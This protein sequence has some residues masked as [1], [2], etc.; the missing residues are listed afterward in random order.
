MNDSTLTPFNFSAPPTGINLSAQPSKIPGPKQQ[1]KKKKETKNCVE[2]ESDDELMK[3]NI[4]L[5]TEVA[6]LQ[7]SEE[8]WK[9]D[10]DKHS[11]ILRKGNHLLVKQISENSTT[12][13][14]QRVSIA[15]LEAELSDLQRDLKS[16][17]LELERAEEANTT[18]T[19]DLEDAQKKV[20]DTET[21]LATANSTVAEH[22]AT[23]T[24]LEKQTGDDEN[25]ATEKQKEFD[26]LQ[27]KFNTAETDLAVEKQK[28]QEKQELAD[29]RQR[30][31]VGLSTQLTE[32]TA[33]CDRVTAERDALQAEVDTHQQ[34][35]YNLKEAR[36]TIAAL[37][38]QLE[39]FQN[40]ILRR[41]FDLGPT[42]YTTPNPTDDEPLA[43]KPS[44]AQEFAEVGGS[45]I[46][47]AASLVGSED[48][49]RDHSPE[50]AADDTT[51]K[52]ERDVT[53]PAQPPKVEIQTVTRVI[54]K[55]FEV[56]AHNPLVCWIQTELNYVILFSVWLQS[57]HRLVSHFLQRC[58]GSPRRSAPLAAEDFDVSPPGNA[59]GSQLTA[60][61]FDPIIAQTH[62]IQLENERRLAEASQLLPDIEKVED[63]REVIG[64]PIPP[65]SPLSA[66]HMYAQTVLG[67]LPG[68][69]SLP[70][71]I[72]QGRPWYVKIISPLP[73]EL[74]SVSKT[75]IGLA[76]HLVIYY[77]IGLGYLCYHERN[78]W[79]AANDHTR[80]FVQQLT[81]NQSSN[82]SVV[83][84]FASSLP[85]HWKHK[86]D[87]FIFKYFV[88]KLGL[89]ATYAMPG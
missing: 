29:T 72:A 10:F 6:R 60:P 18:L 71:P 61:A 81:H 86:I 39:K 65:A 63:N 77:C 14:N 31:N 85:E 37:K 70:G 36:D 69:T 62:R 5:Q 75:L 7:V 46:S 34:T 53:E 45:T 52:F 4:R 3:E 9:T 82:Q 28:T 80:A 15:D 59:W 55:P 33:E 1:K 30:E 35:E 26:A 11:S 43:E 44:L 68:A 83:Q 25:A 41:P 16:E 88:E 74:P 22:A 51:L 79:I 54:Y 24:A 21:K 40:D 87:V 17:K 73:H 56:A 48:G 50:P 2:K 67:P 13:D 23:I 19:K 38:D 20:K 78:M 76:L 27:T 64:D 8:T 12:M 84:Y 47:S 49:E 66:R 58:L 32:K 42:A 89:H 57:L